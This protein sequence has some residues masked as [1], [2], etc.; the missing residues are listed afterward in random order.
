MK[1]HK[2]FI[3]IALSASC[4]GILAVCFFLSRDR[5]PEFTP[6]PPQ[7]SS[8][9]SWEEKRGSMNSGNLETAPTSSGTDSEEYP[10]ATQKDD[11]NV[12]IEFTPSSEDLKPD[13]P[14]APKT[15]A[16][17]TNPS[18]PPS[19]T[20]EQVNPPVVKK[21]EDTNTPA[22]GSKNE[23]GAVY[24][25]VFGW[26]VPGEIEQTPIDNNGDPNKQVGEMGP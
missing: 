14:D 23:N 15:D 16:D 7:S 12:D 22:P 3:I 20:P 6:D 8:P 11:R 26:I 19:Y 1:K 18:A 5:T 4:I 24:D 25:P 17:N 13:A 2:K 9:S 10:K 21:S